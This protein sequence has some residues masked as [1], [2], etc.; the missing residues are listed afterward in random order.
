MNVE[1]LQFLLSQMEKN[2]DEAFYHSERVAVLCYVLAKE[3][4]LT[5][6]ES[7]LVYFA[8]LFH[9]IGK[10]NISEKITYKDIPIDL[11]K[12]YPYFTKILLSFYNKN[13]QLEDIILKHCENFDGTGY[14]K[15]LMFGEIGLLPMIVRISDCY[16][17]HR[18]LG[19]SHN[20]AVKLLEEKANVIFSKQII[21]PFISAVV[22][23]DLQYEYLS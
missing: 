10:I 22:S 4:Q 15:G 16:D 7:E 23:N 18:I 6:D 19:C 12:F 21:K 14:P 3:L 11:E 13:K 8:G 9:E 1:D 2:M 17:N 5:D 20:D